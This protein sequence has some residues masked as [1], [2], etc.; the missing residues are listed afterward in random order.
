[1]RE[2]PIIFSGKMVKAILNDRKTQTRRVVKLH[3]ALLPRASVLPGAFW[4][5]DRLWVRE[6]WAKIFDTYPYDEENPSH[7]EYKADTGAK[8]PGGWPDDMGDDPECLKWKSP[9]YMSRLDSRITLQVTDVRIERLQE[10]SEEDAINEGVSADEGDRFLAGP[11]RIMDPKEHFKT[12]WNSI[13]KKK[14]CWEDNPYV[15][16]ITFYNRRPES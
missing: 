2:R 16:V 5:D 1:M 6:T 14:D 7:V 3:P 13:H 12:I 11:D 4:K 15:W 10:I 8:Y 9:I